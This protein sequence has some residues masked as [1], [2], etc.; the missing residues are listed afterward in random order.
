VLAFF[1][2]ALGIRGGPSG[3]EKFGV[4]EDPGAGGLR[5]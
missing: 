5:E 2:F 4:A 1:G 3:E